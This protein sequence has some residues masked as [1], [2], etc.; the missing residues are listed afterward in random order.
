MIADN[1]PGMRTFG[2]SMSD[3]AF[4]ELALSL[5]APIAMKMDGFNLVEAI[6]GQSHPS[7]STIM[8]LT[9]GGQRGDAAR[10]KFRTY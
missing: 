4:H 7:T 1:S 9:S 3:L 8:M 5:S 2:S 6:K 10:C